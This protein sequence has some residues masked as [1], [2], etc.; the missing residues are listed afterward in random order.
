MEPYHENLRCHF[1]MENPV[2][3]TYDVIKNM[4]DVNEAAYMLEVKG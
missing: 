1:Q 2:I 4:S 3:K